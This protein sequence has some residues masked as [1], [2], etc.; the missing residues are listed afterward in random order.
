MDVAIIGASGDC[1]KQIAVQLVAERVLSPTERLQLVGRRGGKSERML[2]GLRSDLSD[3]YAETAPDLDVSLC[4]E[5]VVADIIVMA[6]GESI[7]TDA[8]SA[9]SR[10][11]L[12][13]RN[14]LVFH[15]Y[16]RAIEKYGH[17]NEV[18]IIVTNPVEL[19]VEIFS[20][21]LGR[22]RV[23]GIGAYSDSLRFRRE[24]ASDVG[25]RRQMVHAFVVGE[26]GEQAVP[27]WSSVRI[28]GMD[29]EEML[30]ITQRLRGTRNVTNFSAEVQ[31]EKLNVV[32]YLQQGLVRE[33]FEHVDRLSPDLRVVL[34]PHLTHLSG[35]KTAVATANVTVDLVRTLMDGREIVVAGQVR[36]DGEFYGIHTSIG[37]PI[38][39]DNH[40]WS[41]VV[42]IQLW[43]DEA[44]LLMH[45][46][47][48]VQRKIREW[49]KH[50]G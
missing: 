8:L 29:M 11:T 31:R 10:D 9:P 5:E 21:Y 28:Y 50:G 41:Q 15:S 26:H 44:R 27:L 22:H 3:A 25:V 34:K 43:E 35:A 13:L 37:A 6:A 17:G 32:A 20:R 14:Q 39:V 18:V 7:P 42:P 48:Q 36:L 38:V 19:G 40:G 2:F 12:A 47:S 46:A 1:G 45:S 4:P 24:I 33:A 23:I 30:A 49:T 16:A